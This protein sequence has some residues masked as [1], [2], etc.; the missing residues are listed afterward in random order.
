MGVTSKHQAILIKGLGQ[1]QSP[2]ICGESCIR[3]P[4]NSEGWLCSLFLE[5]ELI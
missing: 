5:L 4:L 2:H 3:F 1:T